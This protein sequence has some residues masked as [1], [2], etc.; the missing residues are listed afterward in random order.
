M[1]GKE[2]DEGVPGVRG[3]G[4]E[5]SS[6]AGE[7]RGLD[8]YAVR[9]SAAGWGC[10]ALFG[11][12]VGER[13]AAAGGEG[14]V[15]ECADGARGGAAV[16]GTERV[17]RGGQCAAAVCG[18]RGLGGAVVGGQRG[19]GDVGREL[20]AES[21]DRGRAA[22]AAVAVRRHLMGRARGGTQPRHIGAG[23]EGRR[24]CFGTTTKECREST[25]LQVRGRGAPFHDHHAL[26]G[27][28]LCAHSR[29]PF[30]AAT[31][32]WR[33]R[34]RQQKERYSTS[35]RCL[36][37]PQC[38]MS[39]GEDVVLQCWNSA[40]LETGKSASVDV[41]LSEQGAST[42]ALHQG[43]SSAH[44]LQRQRDC[45]WLWATLRATESWLAALRAAREHERTH[46]HW[47]PWSRASLP[48]EVSTADIITLRQKRAR[49]RKC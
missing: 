10:G 29:T 40:A 48:G 45:C 31:D 30:H 32:E 38:L 8:L 18:A 5:D 27:L 41:L 12:Q 49:G 33:A 11:V 22:A 17:E 9:E 43:R 37:G 15:S 25:W 13:A 44:H 14:A 34:C 35:A 47:A 2:R 7:E 16:R 24:S 46:P 42:A 23:A 3:E 1:R 26:D 36:K 20:R 4:E 19:G 39:A 28:A 21:D 6:V